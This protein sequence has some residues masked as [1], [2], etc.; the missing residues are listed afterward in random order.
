MQAK[1]SADLTPDQLRNPDTMGA[2]VRSIVAEV[3][4]M[5]GLSGHMD[6]FTQ[7]YTDAATKRTAD[8]D[9]V[10]VPYEVNRTVN[11]ANH[12]AIKLAY[13]VKTPVQWVG[14]TNDG[15]VKTVADTWQGNLGH[16]PIVDGEHDS[17]L[18]PQ[19][20]KPAK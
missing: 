8:A 2:M 20:G 19:I 15:Q 13:G 16:P 5:H 10:S 11:A 3:E 4:Q 7:R 9:A 17:F 18:V 12:E 14:G 1:Y 6:N